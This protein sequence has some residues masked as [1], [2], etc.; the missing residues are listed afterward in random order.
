MT[1]GRKRMSHAVVQQVRLPEGG[2]EEGMKMLNEIVIPNA[3]AQAGFEKGTWMQ[4][5]DNAGMGV[6]VF[7]TIEH[8]EAAQRAYAQHNARFR[9]NVPPES[10]VDRQPESWGEH[11]VEQNA[12][13]DRRPRIGVD[14][15]HDLVHPGKL[16]QIGRL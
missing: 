8:A 3:K 15:A 7:D 14:D 5:P 13:G 4:T 11:T 16:V 1:E 9:A 10:L 12:A 6:V 2:A